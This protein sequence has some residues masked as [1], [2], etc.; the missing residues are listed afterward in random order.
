MTERRLIFSVADRLYAAP[1]PAVIEVVKP[2]PT[3]WIPNVPP[4]VLGVANFRGAVIP[5][6]DGG[7]LLGFP[8]ET[9]SPAARVVIVERP[10]QG[11]RD[12]VGILVRRFIGIR[13]HNPAELK[14]RESIAGR[15]LH[16]AVTGLSYLDGKSV[17]HLDL[18]ALLARPEAPNR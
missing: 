18:A 13:P 1:L 14:P 5:V 12:L 15:G 10:G 4:A 3:A 16:P 6:A 8:P 17:M 9:P 11:G 2:E 7:L